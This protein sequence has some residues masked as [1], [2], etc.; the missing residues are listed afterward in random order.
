MPMK[1]NS[2]QREKS[3]H[4]EESK[5]S[6]EKSRRGENGDKGAFVEHRE[7]VQ[8]STKAAPAGEKGTEELAGDRLKLVCKSMS[9]MLNNA[10]EVSELCFP[11]L[12]GNGEREGR[13]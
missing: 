9:K 12:V 4:L 10:A 1:Q 11:S 2:F 7:E 8:L 5:S 13:S 6:P 3:G